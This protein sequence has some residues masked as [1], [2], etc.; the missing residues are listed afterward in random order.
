MSEAATAIPPE[1]V[2]DPNDLNNQNMDGDG[3][4]PDMRRVGSIEE[5]SSPDVPGMKK[6]QSEALPNTLGVQQEGED[7]I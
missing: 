1:T 2:G 7:D 4:S 3:E 6:I 5:E